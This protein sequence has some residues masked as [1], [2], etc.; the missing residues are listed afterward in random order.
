M[1]YIDLAVFL[2]ASC[3][4]SR[5]TGFSSLSTKIL[6]ACEPARHLGFADVHGLQEGLSSADLR[7]REGQGWP[8]ENVPDNRTF[9]LRELLNG[10]NRRHLGMGSGSQ[11]RLG[12]FIHP[13]MEVLSQERLAASRQVQD[14]SI[15]ILCL[16]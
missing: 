7:S 15:T 1:R 13:G 16:K 4:N 8:G 2:M 14:L 10:I 6:V 5:L 12:F 9:Q 11:D 3:V